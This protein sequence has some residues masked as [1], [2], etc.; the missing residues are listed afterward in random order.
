MMIQNLFSVFA[1]IVAGWVIC[2]NWSCIL[3]YLLKGKHSSWVP[4][5]GGGLGCLGCVLSP[6][7]V[8]NKLWW[9]PLLIDWGCVPGLSVSLVFLAVLFIRR[10]KR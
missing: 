9:V 4:I 7:A 3:V 10:R 1:L 2:C 5:L 8:L 6:Y